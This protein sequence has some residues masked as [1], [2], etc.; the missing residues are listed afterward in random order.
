MA[1]PP[2]VETEGVAATHPIAMTTPVMDWAI[3]S[4]AAGTVQMSVGE[5]API[6]TTVVTEGAGFAQDAV[7]DP[8]EIDTVVE[9]VAVPTTQLAVMTVALTETVAVIV[10]A[11]TVQLARADPAPI[12]RFAGIAVLRM[13][14]NG[15]AL[16]SLAI[17]RRC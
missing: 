11:G 17:F 1:A 15:C 2:G 12:D 10:T 4:V 6:D 8:A 13:T 3:K 7:A 5:D 16:P 14:L 9:T